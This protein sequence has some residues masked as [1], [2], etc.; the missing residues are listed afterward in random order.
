[1]AMVMAPPVDAGG[2][3]A[4]AGNKRVVGDAASN[5]VGIVVMESIK[6]LELLIF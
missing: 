4:Y 3:V 1:M 6:S 5:E 2:P